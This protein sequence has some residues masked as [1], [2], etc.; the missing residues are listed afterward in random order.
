MVAAAI[1]PYVFFRWKKW[2]Q[3][4]FR[5]CA[6]MRAEEKIRRAH[7]ERE[8]TVDDRLDLDIQQ[9]KSDLSYGEVGFSFARIRNRGTVADR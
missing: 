8:G 6:N 5:F 3:N 9:R 7:Q 4:T 1:G 2:L